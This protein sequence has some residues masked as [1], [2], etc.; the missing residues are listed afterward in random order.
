MP[1]TAL[2]TGASSGIGLELARCCAREGHRVVLVARSADK[3][4]ELAGALERDH[5]VESVVMPADLSDPDAPRKLADDLSE[6]NIDI[7]WLVNNA[8]FGIAGRF[9]H[10]DVEKQRNL[11][12]VNMEAPMLLTR[13]LGGPMVKRGS[14]R[15]LNVASV[16]AFVPG[17]FMANYYA[18]KAYLVS[19]SLAVREEWAKHG[20]SVS[21]LCPGPTKTDFFGNAGAES[22]PIAEGA[23]GGGLKSAA[24]VAELGYRGMLKGKPIIIPG[25]ANKFGA[26]ATR[27]IPRP[28]AASMTKKYNRTDEMNASSQSPEA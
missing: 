10:S 23:G 9:A 5:G 20:V 25:L 26:F 4:T 11:L 8:G 14:G 13:V 7:D 17:P 22:A 27:L 15:V 28:F 1:Q 3:L 12:R 16:A 2:I 24:Q 18:S 6:R 21:V 19:F